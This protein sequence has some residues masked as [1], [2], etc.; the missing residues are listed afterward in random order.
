MTFSCK[1]A[2]I[3]PAQLG[4]RFSPACAV[5]APASLGPS[6]GPQCRCLTNPI[7]LDHPKVVSS[8]C[9]LRIASIMSCIACGSRSLMAPSSSTSALRAAAAQFSTSAAAS[10]KLKTHKG[11]AKRW[12]PVSN[13]SVGVVQVSLSSSYITD[14]RIVRNSSSGF[15]LQ[16]ILRLIV[17]PP[18]D[19][20][21]CA[22]SVGSSWKATLELGLCAI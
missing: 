19:L 4:A 20:R 3:T 14:R 21:V 8:R 16:P 15:V 5:R 22:S 17:L 11:A 13:G 6:C 9:S 10:N 12:K 7:V 1:M 18:A 2:L